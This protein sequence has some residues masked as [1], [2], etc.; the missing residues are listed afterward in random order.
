MKKLMM[1]ALTGLILATPLAQAAV[2]VGEKAPDFTLTDVSGKSRSLSEFAG[3]TVVLE[4]TNPGCPFV[5]K[6]Y[7]SGNIPRQQADTVAA[8]AVWLSINSSAKG[9][10]GDITPAEATELGSQWR[11]APTAYLFDRDGK[12]GQ[13]YGA[14][15]TPHLYVIDGKGLLRYNGA[16]DSIPT[17]RQDDLAKATQYVPG[18]LAAIAAGKEVTPSTTQPYGCNVKY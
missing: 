1:T 6:H 9:K 15:T 10:Q 7:D 12:V 13:A 17:P 14:K 8:G 2:K 3:K 4:W 5:K 16:I 11:T 18:V